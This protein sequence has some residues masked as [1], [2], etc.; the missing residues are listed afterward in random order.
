MMLLLSLTF[1]PL[2]APVLL[3]APSTPEPSGVEMPP[4]E[5]RLQLALTGVLWQW[6]GNAANDGEMTLEPD[7]PENYSVTFQEDGKLA[8]Q[9]DCNRAMGVYTL[10]ESSIDL[11][12]RGV[13]RMLC[14]PGS[15][16]ER[17]LGDLDQA[18]S[19]S[20]DQGTLTLTLPADAGVM[21]FTPELVESADAVPATPATG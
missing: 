17:F 11:Q 20:I 4:G 15:L 1:V 13:T 9:A 14:P 6:Q 10:S 5:L 18:S 19:Y 3:A 21:V 12:I 2:F 7:H 8:I 16:M